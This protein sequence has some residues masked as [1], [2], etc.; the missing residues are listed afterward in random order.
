[1]FFAKLFELTRQGPMVLALS[2]DAAS[3]RMTVN[4][5]P[6]AGK[7]AADAAL[8]KPLTLTGTPAEFD[9]DFI[10]LLGQYREAR[11]TLIEQAEATAE[12]LAAAKQAQVAK[13]AEATAKGRK[14]LPPPKSAAQSAAPAATAA[15]SADDDGDAVVKGDE[16]A[17]DDNL[18]G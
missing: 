5:T 2:A 18:F 7:D 8:R 11:R 10:P 13:A 3:G 17:S 16:P 14:A 15:V 4:V 6:V 1:M 9:A 12:V